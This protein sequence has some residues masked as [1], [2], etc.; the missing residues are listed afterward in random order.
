MVGTKAILETSTDV[1]V[2]ITA[3]LEKQTKINNMT[4]TYSEELSALMEEYPELKGSRAMS[5]GGEIVD[6]TTGEQRELNV[7]AMQ[8]MYPEIYARAYKKACDD[9]VAKAKVGIGAVEGLFTESQLSSIT[10]MKSKAFSMTRR[11]KL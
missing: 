5:K 6:F 10:N 11:G 9:A 2:R 7:K 3:L 1:S 4:A 8:E